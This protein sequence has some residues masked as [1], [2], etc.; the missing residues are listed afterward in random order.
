MRH[1]DPSELE[2]TLRSGKAIEQFLGS[3]GEPNTIA[4]LAVRPGERG[5]ELYHSEVPDSGDIEHLD[6]YEFGGDADT[7]LASISASLDQILARA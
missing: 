7:Q 2:S 5:F 6:L 3:R 4:W 1:L